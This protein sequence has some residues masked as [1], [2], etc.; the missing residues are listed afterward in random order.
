MALASAMALSLVT[1]PVSAEETNSG[2]SA[3][4]TQYGTLDN[5]VESI[6]VTKNVSVSTQGTLLPDLSFTI[7]MEPATGDD[8]C[9]I[10]TKETDS[11]T[12]TVKTDAK[13]GDIVIESA[14]A[15]ANPSLTFTF[16][17]ENSTNN[18]EKQATKTQPFEFKF[19]QVDGK[20]FEF[21]HSGIYR[22]VISETIDLGKDENG[23]PKTTNGFVNYD[24]T[25]YYVDCYVDKDSNNKL[26]LYNYTLTKAGNPTKP[27]NVSFTNSVSCQAVTISKEVVGSEYKPGQFYTFR[28]LIPVGGTSID[29][30]EGTKLLA[31][32]CD[33]GG[34]PVIDTE[35]GRTDDKGNVYLEV[36]GADIDA[37]MTS[38]NTT[39]FKLK[40]GEWLEIVGAPVSMIYKVE[41]VVDEVTDQE[42]G[43]SIKDQQYT[44]T[45]TYSEWGTLTT[46]DNTAIVNKDD[47]TG[48]TNVVQGTVNTKSNAVSFIN[49]R[50]ITAKTG[51][52]LDFAPY[53]LIVLIAV[54][55]GILFIAR[56]RRVER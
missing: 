8:L 23:N 35:N 26:V 47:I 51:I 1:V 42:I 40:K 55:G 45:Y 18:T 21:K 37:E 39:E 13:I 6:G 22:Y 25:K 5:P 32:I 41:E 31:K 56:K 43:K 50:N 36:K 48:T 15:L 10:T 3:S 12:E 24:T 16:N 49:T 14:P 28:I 9:D 34:G 27:K 46:A 7:T 11:G 52:N 44:T 17:A 2:S 29:L 53:V 38:D 54:C 33:A 4:A 20:D 30:A 19:A